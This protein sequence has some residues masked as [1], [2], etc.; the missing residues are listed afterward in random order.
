MLS[1]DSDHSVMEADTYF[2]RTRMSVG[3]VM[4]AKHRIYLDTKYWIYLRDVE[5]GNAT[6]ERK[7]ILRMLRKLVDS[8]KFIC[9]LSHH[10]FS[11]LLKQRDPNTRVLMAKIMDELSQQY[12]FISPDQIIGQE[13]ISFIRNAQAKSTGLPSQTSAKYVWTKVP[14]ILGELYPKLRN[15]TEAQ[16]QTI[17]DQFSDYYSHMSLQSIIE[18]LP[19]GFPL[20]CYGDLT[21]RLNKGKSANQSWK[22][23]HELF[24]HEI[25]GILD[26]LQDEFERVWLYLF[27]VDRGTCVSKEVIKRLRCVEM[28]S[29][30]IFSGFA[31]DKI[32]QELPF[33]YI[34][35]KIHAHVR[36]DKRRRYKPND[37]DDIGHATWALPYCKYFLTEDGLANIISQ[38]KL[39]SYYQTTVLSKETDIIDCLSKLVEE[40]IDGR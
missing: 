2:N 17:A 7:E 10:N 14:F 25:A 37:I 28:L 23:F 12:C 34:R 31:E 38:Q 35:A 33:V 32:R 26:A 22:S 24:M 21:D 5:R 36:Y 19:G 27:E 3:D 9:P 8:Q 29:N 11:E 6:T 16:E 30:L 15:I 18:N 13:I 39:D 40:H 4:T 20:G 1:M